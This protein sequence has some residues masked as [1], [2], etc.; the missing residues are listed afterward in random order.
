MSDQETQS[1]KLKCVSEDELG[2]IISWLDQIEKSEL[3]ITGF[4]QKYDVPFSRAQYYIYRKRFEEFG[5]YERF[6]KRAKGGNRKVTVEI[7]AFISG[8]LASNA[9]TSL[10][11]LQRELLSRYSCKLS[12][13]GITRII[14]RIDSHNGERPRGRPI[15]QDVLKTR[16]SCGGFELIIALAYYL[17]WP[18][19]VAQVIGEAV[20][21]VK[22]ARNIES[23]SMSS[24]KEGRNEHGR[25]TSS[26]NQREDVRQSR[27]E[28]IAIKKQK[29]NLKSMNVVRDESKTIER[30]SLAILSLPVI[31]LNG[32]IRS[33][34][35]AIGQE[36]KHFCGYDYKQNTLVKYLSE[37]KYLGISKEILTQ[38][39]KFWRKYWGD[40]IET[41]SEQSLLCYY[42]DGNTKA[43]WS[44]KRIKQNKVTM[45]G[46]VMGCLEQVF[47]HDCFGH[48]IY[49]ET[50]SGHAPSG[51]Y[52]LE[53]F[54]KIEQAIEEVPG[55]RTSVNRAI[56]IDGAGN[57]VKT[58]RAFAAQ[59]KY[60]YITPLD[61]N[62][63]DERKVSFMGSA[64]RYK[65]GDATLRELEIELEDSQEKGYLIR[66]RS[67]KIDW[68]NGRTTNLLTSFPE[69]VVDCSEVVRCYFERWPAEELQ[70]RSM[71][72][73]VSLNKV[74]GYGKQKLDDAG[75][76]T[77]QKHAEKMIGQLKEKLKKPLEE[78]GKHE[79]AIADL[80]PKERSLRNES[81]IVN[82]QRELPGEQMTQFKEIDKQIRKHK[83]EIKN[84]ELQEKEKFKHLRKHQREWLRLQG[85]ETVYKVDVEL[86][87]LMTFHRVSLA[88][89]YGYFIKFFM[90]GE[91]ISMVNLLHRIIH[92]GADIEETEDTRRI[93]FDYNRKDS[94]TMSKLC[95]AI[96]KINRLKIIGP[97]GKRMV[98][99]LNANC[100]I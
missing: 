98:F 46:R 11:W 17:E 24:D 100:P 50:Y 96:E 56:V 30:K 35:S 90:N 38:L 71:K 85:K 97:H 60:H 34:N 37:L 7:E 83:K 86:D 54:E 21:R 9:K 73:S 87:Q 82:G 43:V 45:L 52:I 33:V 99:E 3:S 5:T 59:K 47:I 48:P 28:T 68:D 42:I 6:D 80:I 53:L 69:E 72:A 18:Q 61:D 1:R 91:K 94:L 10:D 63:R 2:V 41:Q 66:V 77:R 20:L 64:T 93:I 22:E 88:N 32:T 76:I 62:Q 23:E 44:S 36:I 81:K 75:V 65:Y 49:F 29:K 16:N 26:Y 39:I 51:E 92:L 19:M 89:L 55:A 95:A 13:S 57:S 27:F 70:F 8:C 84:I 31:T 25:F 67:I 4:F 78:I 15:H 40:E 12:L 14:Q 74:A 79:E 58:L